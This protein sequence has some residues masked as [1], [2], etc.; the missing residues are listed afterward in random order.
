MAPPYILVGGFHPI[1]ARYVFQHL[2]GLS[3]RGTYY[4]GAGGPVDAEAC[5]LIL[6][7]SSLVDTPMG[8]PSCEGTVGLVQLVDHPIGGLSCSLMDQFK[9]GPGYRGY[10]WTS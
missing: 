3:M 5:S 2:V 1:G 10:R 4:M 8:G 9:G 7:L 6:V